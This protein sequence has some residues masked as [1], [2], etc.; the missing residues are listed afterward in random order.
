M[1]LE[2]TLEGKGT[3]KLPLYYNAI[4][5]AFVY[6]LLGDIA[7]KIHDEGFGEYRRFKM[8]VFSELFGET[9]RVTGREVEFRSPVKFY[10][11]SP[12][13][14]VIHSIFDTLLR[15][16]PPPQ[17]KDFHV[18]SVN[19]QEFHPGGDLLTVRTLSPITAYQTF[20]DSEGKNK[21]MYFSPAEWEFQDL[22]EKNL[23]RKYK[24]IHGEDYDG[25]LDIQPLKSDCLRDYRL[26]IYKKT[27]IKAWHGEFRIKA[28]PDMLKIALYAGLGPKNSQGF[29]MIREV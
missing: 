21:T 14:F 8:F 18:S 1:R 25:N 12:Y 17:L 4:L 19:I 16:Y 7:Q 15:K 28:S 26:V 5:Q 10:L 9:E 6:R 23:R 27:L 3:L 13:S 22:L 24:I 2:I 20:R 11:A 29:G